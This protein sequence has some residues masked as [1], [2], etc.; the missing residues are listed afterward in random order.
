MPRRMGR[1]RQRR[2]LARILFNTA[3]SVSVLAFVGLIVW[4]RF[5]PAPQ[6]IA[7]SIVM[8]NQEN[9]VYEPDDDLHSQLLLVAA[10]LPVGWIIGRGLRL[11]APARHPAGCCPACG[12]DLRATPDR[13]PE[14]GT[15]PAA[16]R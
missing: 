2:R 15:V 3:A 1:R 4:R 13:C 16:P 11:L 8:L 6:R 12:Y 10:V 7:Y 9:P 14:C 5:V